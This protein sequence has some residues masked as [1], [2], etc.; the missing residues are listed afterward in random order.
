M[1]DN[2]LKIKQRYGLKK[3]TFL[4]KKEIR[5]LEAVCI[6]VA[7]FGEGRGGIGLCWTANSLKE[8]TNFRLKMLVHILT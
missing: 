6:S 8:R 3:S 7:V 1:N 5:C 4:E 2:Q